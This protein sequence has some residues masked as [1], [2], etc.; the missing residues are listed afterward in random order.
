MMR[1]NAKQSEF[2][3]FLWQWQVEER[4]ARSVWRCRKVEHESTVGGLSIVLV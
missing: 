2:F 4:H 3:T 1:V